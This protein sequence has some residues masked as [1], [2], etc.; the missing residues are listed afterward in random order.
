MGG[1]GGAMRS[2]SV[3]GVQNAFRIGEMGAQSVQCVQDRYDRCAE[4]NT[5]RIPLEPNHQL[6]P[7]ASR[8]HARVLPDLPERM[9]DH[10]QNSTAG[11]S[12]KD[13]AQM[14][15]WME[16]GRQTQRSRAE[17]HATSTANRLGT[18]A[19]KIVATVTVSVAARPLVHVLAMAVSVLVT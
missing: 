14:D 5:G 15:G 9:H 4:S 13:T 12:A 7:Q 1:Q 10:L 17:L 3:H 11:G 18:S 6:H 8:G 16:G 19:R 2:A